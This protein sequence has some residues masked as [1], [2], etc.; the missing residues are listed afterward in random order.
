MVVLSPAGRSPLRALVITTFCV[1]AGF[2]LV[3]PVTPLF[4]RQLGAS[5][6]LVGLT[7]AGFGLAS[8]CFDLIGGR[9]GERV[10]A[11][12]AAAGGAALVAVASL[13]G[14]LAP[15]VPVLLASR[16]ITGAGSAIYV[17]TAM[18][19]IAR[20]TPPE[21][22][23]R[24]MGTYQSAIL[25]STA[26][27]PSIGGLLAGQAGLRAPFVLYAI[28]AAGAALAALWLLPQR[29]PAPAPR[30]LGEEGPGGIGRVLRGGALQIALATAFVV[31]I[32][33]QGVNS[34]AVPVYANEGLGL[35][36][37]HVGLA[38]SVSAL[39]NFLFLP[40]AGRLV[41]RRPRGVAIRLGLVATLASL[42]LL[43]GPQ[44]M[45][46][47]YAGMF[48]MG[49]ATAYAGVAPAAV[50]TDVTPPAH[51]ATAM[52]IYRMAIDAGSV[53][54]PLAAGML[55]AGLGFRGVFLAMMAPVVVLLLATV[56]LPDTRAAHPGP[57]GDR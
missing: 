22:M 15:S 51:S 18:N 24:S 45:A 29:L 4:A 53:S 30:R 17:T 7:V 33:R 54:G 28:V 46:G 16:F 57:V 47:L 5:A 42:L 26:I 40:H 55:T 13:V 12:R 3:S 32:L 43:G 11:A 56:R 49:V 25:S 6:A 9:I 19:I 27:G 10:G 50:I 38:L 37:G 21:R 31:F 44:S 35:G 41:D 1:Y 52:G 34:T 20:T 48:V 8:F 36:R 14:V 2:G 39:A 23:G